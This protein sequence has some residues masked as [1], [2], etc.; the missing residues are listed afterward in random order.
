MKKY[1]ERNISLLINPSQG[2]RRPISCWNIVFVA[3]MLCIFVG[4]VITQTTCKKCSQANQRRGPD[5]WLWFEAVRRSEKSRAESD[6]FGKK[7]IKTMRP[8]K[9]WT[10]MNWAITCPRRYSIPEIHREAP[11]VCLRDTHSRFPYRKV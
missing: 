1:A 6:S 9:L 5:C 2:H 10:S 3:I 4:L 8:R 7:S 11:L